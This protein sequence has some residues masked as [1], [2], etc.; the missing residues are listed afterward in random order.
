MVIVSAERGRK[1]NRN[2]GGLP[3]VEQIRE[4][5]GR[6]FASKRGRPG[7]PLGNGFRAYSA[8][9]LDTL[10]QRAACR[11]GNGWRSGR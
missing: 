11:P 10:V 3:D 4:Q 2:S 9:H 6:M 5:F 7:E 8:K 1:E